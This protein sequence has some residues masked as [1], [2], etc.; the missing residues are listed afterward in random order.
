MIQ[1]EMK[2]RTRKTIRTT[3][4]Q[5]KNEPTGNKL[6]KVGRNIEHE[7]KEQGSQRWKKPETGLEKADGAK[8]G[9]TPPEGW[10]QH[11]RAEA[12]TGDKPGEGWLSSQQQGKDDRT[13]EAWQNE[14]RQAVRPTHKGQ[15]KKETRAEASALREERWQQDVKSVTWRRQPKRG[16]EKADTARNARNRNAGRNG[17]K[18]RGT[19]R[20]ECRETRWDKLARRRTQH[21]NATRRRETRQRQT[22]F[23]RKAKTSPSHPFTL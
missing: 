22:A 21:P 19:M 8:K 1:D 5:T 18:K 13:Q 9:D 6:L 11:S 2:R 15:G 10:T 12:A 3:S 14:G 17:D 23:D 20:H 7:G 16:D 4:R